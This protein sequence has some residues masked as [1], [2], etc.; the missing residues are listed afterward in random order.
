ML[1]NSFNFMRFL[2]LKISCI[3][4]TKFLVPLQF[5]GLKTKINQI[6]FQILQ[7]KSFSEF[8]MSVLA[9]LT[10]HT[11]WFTFNRDEGN[12]LLE[13]QQKPFNNW[14]VWLKAK[15]KYKALE[16]VTTDVLLLFR[17]IDLCKETVS[18]FDRQ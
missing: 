8:W 16:N 4:P 15:Y 14:R 9:I 6:Y 17:S 3:S 10:C 13:F 2:F 12:S 18:V 1:R 5:K 11:S 7:I